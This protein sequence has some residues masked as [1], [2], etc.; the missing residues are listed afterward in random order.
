MI[1]NG[2]SIF[3]AT[4][5]I[6][7]FFFLAL[8]EKCLSQS[9]LGCCQITADQTCTGCGEL[10]CA[11]TSTECIEVLSGVLNPDGVCVD[12]SQPCQDTTGILGCCVLPEGGCIENQELFGS[13]SC[14][15][16]N[17]IAWFLQDCS[18]VPECPQF[19]PPIN[20]IPIPTLSQW[21][22]IAMAGILGVIGFI[23][24]IRR[25][26]VTA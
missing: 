26:K 2:V 6:I 3:I 15:D 10:D 13:P 11:I 19:V 17:G 5:L 24:V 14:E 12:G 8:P 1:K 25:K 20:N 21:G 22:L 9:N 7:G 18:E 4:F 23:M 16:E